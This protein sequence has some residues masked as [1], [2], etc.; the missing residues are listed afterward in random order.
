MDAFFALLRL[1]CASFLFHY[2]LYISVTALIILMYINGHLT[3]SVEVHSSIIVTCVWVYVCVCVFK[4]PHCGD[5]I[6]VVWFADWNNCKK[7]VFRHKCCKYTVQQTKTSIATVGGGGSQFWTIG[8][9]MS[10]L[11]FTRCWLS[12]LM[13]ALHTCAHTHTHTHTEST[14]KTGFISR[15]VPNQ[16]QIT[17]LDPNF[18]G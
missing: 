5:C 1:S 2:Y 14:V 13:L 3:E 18:G 7:M 16:W 11:Y 6:C 12:V 8:V 15:D 9:V 4:S 17:H 10:V